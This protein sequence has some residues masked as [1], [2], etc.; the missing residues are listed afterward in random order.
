MS[1]GDLGQRLKPFV[2]LDYVDALGG[3][4]PR[5]G[6]HPHSGIATLT[7][8]ITFD[9][10][11]ESSSGQVDVVHR[12]GV[13]WVVAGAGIWHRAQPLSA[14]P[15]QGFQLWFALP[16][17]HETAPAQARFIPP[18]EVP[19]SGPVTVLL[20]SYGGALSPLDTPLDASCFWVQ[21][22]AGDSWQYAPPPEHQLAWAFAQS[23]TLEVGG[24]RPSRE[25][26]VFE[27]GNHSIDFHAVSDCSFLLGS[28]AKH[29]HNLV[30]GPYSVHTS[31]DALAAGARRIEEVG[32]RLQSTGRLGP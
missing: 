11:H 27:D 19:R 29:G 14:G 24:E 12:G 22:K 23:G 32:A 13:E 1:P 6:F 20:G 2:F 10:E 26:I 5:F 17:S 25:L 30:L 31:T 28:A 16:P 3:A 9:I 18:G 7:F 15:L 21:L 4:G 8:P